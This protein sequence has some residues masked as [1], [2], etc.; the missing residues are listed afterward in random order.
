MSSAGRFIPPE[1]MRWLDDVIGNSPY[2]VI[3]MQ[4]VP[5]DEF[6]NGHDFYEQL[7]KMEMVT[8]VIH[9]HRHEPVNME[10][11]HGVPVLHMQALLFE[12]EPPL[13]GGNIVSIEITQD[14]MII[15]AKAILSACGTDQTYKIDRKD[16]SLKGAPLLTGC[17]PLPK[18]EQA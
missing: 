11:P 13:P 15:K 2:P 14:E 7:A 16:L 9:G 6:D 5:P 1:H 18:P 8:L 10:F 4:H 17:D 12:N 3:L